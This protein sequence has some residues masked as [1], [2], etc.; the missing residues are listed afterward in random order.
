MSK[1]RAT[2]IRKRDG[3]I[4]VVPDGRRPRAEVR[5][6]ARPAPDAV[7]WGHCLPAGVCVVG[8]AL[9][10]PVIFAVSLVLCL[11]GAG[12]YLYRQSQT[13]K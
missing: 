1:K 2:W 12:L 9:A 8:F 5:T 10:F 13:R 4:I 11:A 7:P 3:T 6:A